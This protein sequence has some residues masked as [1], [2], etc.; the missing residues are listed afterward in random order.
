MMCEICRHTPCASR[1]PNA[2]EQ[3]P[4]TK[5][6][7]CGDGILEGDEF[8]DGPDGPVCKDCMEDMSYLEILEL[9]GE[10]MKVAEVA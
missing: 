9:I 8:F 2:P 10:K 7:Q 1:C 6:L 5:C 4:I 3:K